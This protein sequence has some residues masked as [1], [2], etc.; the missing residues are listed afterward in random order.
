V[1]DTAYAPADRPRG[2]LLLWS[3]AGLAAVAAIVSVYLLWLSLTSLAPAGCGPSSGC[4]EVL[5]S[6]W[7]R[8]FGLPVSALAVAAYLA[9]VGVAILLPRARPPS[10]R[11]LLA[12]ALLALGLAAGGAAG[13]FT[14][15]QFVRLGHLC[16]YCLGV[17][18]CGLLLT[19]LVIAWVFLNCRGRAEA[20]VGWRGGLIAAA[21]AVVAVT[22][23]A[24]G[25]VLQPERHVPQQPA[26]AEPYHLPGGSLAVDLSQVPRLGPASAPHAV[27]VLA[28]YTCPHC[29][30]LHAALPAVIEHYK[31]QVS[32]AL[33][34]V[35]MNS[36]CNTLIAVTDP[37]HTFACDLAKL[38][39]A[40]WRA[41]PEAYAEMD[42][43]L[44]APEEPRTP[45]DARR[46]AVGLVGEAALARAEADPWVAQQLSKD[47]EV[48][49][50]A[51][52]GSIPKLIFQQDAVSYP[53]NDAKELIHLIDY[54]LDLKPTP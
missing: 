19:V 22:T 49:R 41:K 17:H 10:R 8:W 47:I 43:Y 12:M 13:W 7:S 24:V 53:P 1:G 39:L 5:T 32:L 4:E 14:Y 48:Y 34:P 27:I 23:V 15:L 50:V 29:R 21:V 3:I 40:V 37:R 33:M 35:A 42:S 46:K 38:A 45:A 26:R 44:F 25:Q 36:K 31:G 54:Q 16:P 9:I 20:A 51:G 52:A 2:R 18:V 6:R 28:D 11:P 30:D